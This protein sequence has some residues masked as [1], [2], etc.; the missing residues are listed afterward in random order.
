[1]LP[2]SCLAALP[3]PSCSAEERLVSNSTARV[4]ASALGCMPWRLHHRTARTA[5]CLIGAARDT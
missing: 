4:R 1:M 5:R 2:P 3:H